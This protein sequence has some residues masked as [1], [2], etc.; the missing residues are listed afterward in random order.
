MMPD[1]SSAPTI[2]WQRINT[3]SKIESFRKALNS[4]KARSDVNSDQELK[5][6]CSEL[7]SLFIYYLLKEMR[8]T[9]PK[10][11]FISGG[12]AEDIYTSMLDS[13]LAKDLSSKGGIGLSSM[14]LN[15]L[16]CGQGYMKSRGGYSPGQAE[17]D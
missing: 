17:G 2:S 7:E 11:G 12:K 16:S 14:L 1:L 8:A 6:A 4:E 15:Q 3:D 13:Q 9:V 10:S 5:K